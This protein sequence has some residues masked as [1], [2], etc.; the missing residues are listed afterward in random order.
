MARDYSRPGSTRRTSELCRV[1][2]SRDESKGP[3]NGPKNLIT[4]VSVGII[5][6]SALCNR[7]PWSAALADDGFGE[8]LA[9]DG[10]RLIVRVADVGVGQLPLEADP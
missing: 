5:R 3:G 8:R 9:F 2:F 10:D 7:P 1:V 4:R 6:D